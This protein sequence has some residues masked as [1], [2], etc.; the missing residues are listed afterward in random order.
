MEEA[1][2]EDYDGKDAKG[3]GKFGS[4][5]GTL[6]SAYNFTVLILDG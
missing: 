4:Q 5:S 2:G 6:I 3:R 1:G